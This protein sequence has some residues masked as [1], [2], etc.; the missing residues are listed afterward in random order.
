MKFSHAKILQSA[1]ANPLQL[2]IGVALLIGVVY[3]LGRKTLSDVAS[4]VGGIASGNNAI[5][6]GTAYED[7]GLAGTV[8]ASVDSVLGG[9]PS[10]LGESIGGWWYDV[11][12]KPYDPNAPNT[13]IVRRQATESSPV[14]PVDKPTTWLTY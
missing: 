5:T 3:Y 9:F 7:T 12:N 10:W 14:Q 6:K 11:V 2:A 8:G 13:T 4:G 1:A